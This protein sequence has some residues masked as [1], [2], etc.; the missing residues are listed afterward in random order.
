MSM[1][2]AQRAFLLVSLGLN[3][4]DNRSM[5]DLLDDFYEAYSGGGLGGG[6]APAE[7]THDQTDITGAL[8]LENLP[9]GGVFVVNFVS[10]NWRYN[11]TTITERPTSR[12]DVRM[13]AVGGTVAPA[14]GITHDMWFE[15]LG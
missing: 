10:P 14:F 9:P 12:T 5:S 8:S 6:G 13:F 4:N 1:A 11:N 7:H 2:D 3:P 15:D